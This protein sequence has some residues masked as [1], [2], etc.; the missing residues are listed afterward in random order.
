MAKALSEYGIS[1]TGLSVGIHSFQ[2]VLEDGFMEHFPEQEFSK[3]RIKA[4]VQLEKKV[5]LSMELTIQL[6]GLVE[7]RCDRSDRPFD[8]AVEAD[9][10][11]VVHFGEAF[12]NDD[13]ELLIIPHGEHQLNVAQLLYELLV[14]SIP[15]KKLYPGT[16]E[17]EPEY[18]SS[19]S[20]DDEKTPDPRW[21]GLNALKQS[22]AE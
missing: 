2:Y 18:Y 9:R 5:N 11:V 13:D 10:F 20:D 17:E 3:L 21:A 14:Q 12:N 16:E 1:F 8:M 6:A 19:S 7:V 22:Q 4:E 15:L